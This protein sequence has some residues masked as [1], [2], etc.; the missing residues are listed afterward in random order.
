MNLQE[1]FDK[2][3][4][5]L[6]RTE[7]NPY[8]HIV[9]PILNHTNG[10]KFIGPWITL[11]DVTA[12]MEILFTDVPSDGWLEWKGTVPLSMAETDGIQRVKK[13]ARK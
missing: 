10:K 9:Q 3:I 13:K 7:W 6:T 2:G 5:R 11:H 4:E 8:A 12:S 1:A